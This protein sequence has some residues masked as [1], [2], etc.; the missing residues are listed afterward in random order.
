MFHLNRLLIFVLLLLVFSCSGNK[1]E[2]IVIEE[3]DLEM[4]LEGILVKHK[5]ISNHAN[6]DNSGKKK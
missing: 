1:K 3:K 5:L 6:K 4:Q 2:E